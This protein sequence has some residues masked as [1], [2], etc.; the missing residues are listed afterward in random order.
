L[1]QCKTKRSCSERDADEKGL[2]QSVP[3][4]GG[5]AFEMLEEVATPGVGATRTANAN[6]S[7]TLSAKVNE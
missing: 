7:S 5:A 4:G 6:L 1:A 3:A 2:C